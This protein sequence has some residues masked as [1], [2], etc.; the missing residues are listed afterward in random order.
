MFWSGNSHRPSNSEAKKKY[1][2]FRFPTNPIFFCRPYYFFKVIDRATL[3][4]QSGCGLLIQR[5]LKMCS[6]SLKITGKVLKMCSNPDMCGKN[7]HPL[8]TKSSVFT[9]KTP[10]FKIAFIDDKYMLCLWKW[11][12]CCIK[13]NYF[14]IIHFL[15]K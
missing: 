15:V 9:K 2:W 11:K 5:V 10:A 1:L 4:S 7:F 6:R 8:S 3:F 14:L 13:P 12:V